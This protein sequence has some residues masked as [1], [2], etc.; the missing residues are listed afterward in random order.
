MSGSNRLPL[1]IVV[2]HPAGMAELELHT[3]PICA[4]DWVKVLIV[5]SELRG[6]YARA[7]KLRKVH[8]SQLL[9]SLRII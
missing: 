7:H 9:I 5:Q 1:C 3:S 8:M 2:V 4:V 6:T